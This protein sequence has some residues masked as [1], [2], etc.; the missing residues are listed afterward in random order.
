MTA[1]TKTGD[2]GTGCLTLFALPFCG[3]G[4]WLAYDVVG[5]FAPGV[6]DWQQ[7]TLILMAALAFGGSGFGLLIWSRIVAG[8]LAEGTRLK[9]AHPDQPWMWKPGWGTG[10][11]EGSSRASMTLAWVMAF[12]TTVLSAPAVI[13][14]PEEVI[15]YTF[16]AVVLRFR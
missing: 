15:D 4:L 1:G 11:I 10:R 2:Q 9:A 6:E 8:K 5:R 14:I 3:V 13:L 12:F 16:S 7:L